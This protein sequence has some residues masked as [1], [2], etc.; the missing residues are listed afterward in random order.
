[1]NV[2]KNDGEVGRNVKRWRTTHTLYYSSYDAR[3]CM[4]FIWQS[5]GK[6]WNKYCAHVDRIVFFFY[7]I[8]FWFFTG[9]G[10]GTA[11]ARCIAFEASAVNNQF[12]SVPYVVI[13]Y[14][15]IAL[16]PAQA[17]PSPPYCFIA[18]FHFWCTF[19][20]VFE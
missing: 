17:N 20:P 11:C 5:C 4:R 9:V 10:G 19:G 3:V 14:D 15:F 1:M 8:C 13:E 7:N 6:L 12:L 16:S 2:G 18:L